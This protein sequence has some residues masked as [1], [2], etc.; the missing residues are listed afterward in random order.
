MNYAKALQ[1]AID[2]APTATG[3]IKRADIEAQIAAIGDE[4]KRPMGNAARIMLCADRA[5]LRKAL[6]ALSQTENEDGT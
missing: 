3:G 2:Q 4:L 5:S 6:A 1:K